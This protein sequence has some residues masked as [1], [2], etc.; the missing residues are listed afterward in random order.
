MAGRL[1]RS[2]MAAELPLGQEHRE[3]VHAG[4]EDQREL[5]GIAVVFLGDGTERSVVAKHRHLEKLDKLK[6]LSR[7]KRLDR[8]QLAAF[9]KSLP[10][11]ADA[12]KRLLELTPARYT[13]LAAELAK[14]V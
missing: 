8:R 9:V 4:P 12:R 14:R 10:I 11:P 2:I 5:H 7:G 13:G 3:A 1:Y 6:A